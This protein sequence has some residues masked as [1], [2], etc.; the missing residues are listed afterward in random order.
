[1]KSKYE[2]ELQKLKKENEITDKEVKLLKKQNKEQA[3]IIHDL[4]PNNY[5]GKYQTLQ[6]ENTELKK[7]LKIYEEKFAL[8]RIS[9][10]KD[11]SKSC[12][13]HMRLQNSRERR[14]IKRFSNN[15]SN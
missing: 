15:K 9:L 3:E 13:M 10:E 4:D 7:K 2:Q 1:M 6:L 11:S 8:L 5:R 14:N 12:N